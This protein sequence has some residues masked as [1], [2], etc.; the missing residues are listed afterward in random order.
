M[1]GE[2]LLVSVIVGLFGGWAFGLVMGKGRHGV[3]GDLCLGLIG[4]P[5]AVW[6]YQ[7]VGL[8]AYVGT[9]GGMVAAFM[10]AIG[11]VFV[12]RRLRFVGV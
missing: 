6:T 7:A 4:G 1:T 2:L 12:Q 3:I 10:G 8:A 9:V 5:L 11:V